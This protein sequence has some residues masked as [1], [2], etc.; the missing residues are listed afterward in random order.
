M[1]WHVSIKCQYQSWET[2]HIP[3][4]WGKIVMN[5]TTT[6]SPPHP[7]RPSILFLS[8]PDPSPRLWSFMSGRMNASAKSLQTWTMMTFLL[9]WRWSGEKEGLESGWLYS[10]G[11]D[12]QGDLVWIDLQFILQPLF[13]M[14][15]ASSCTLNLN[16]SKLNYR[17]QAAHISIRT[18]KNCTKSLRDTSASATMGLH[19]REGQKEITGGHYAKL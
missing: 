10:T 19:I 5:W 9:Q 4:L 12:F 6:L 11:R 15:F 1:W 18:T 7:P 3:H 8:V 16:C 2:K 17:D 13:V 14:C